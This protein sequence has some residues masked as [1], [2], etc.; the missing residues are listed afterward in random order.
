MKSS[1]IIR[2]HWIEL[3]SHHHQSMKGNYTECL[4]NAS[5]SYMLQK[6]ISV[7]R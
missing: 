7:R 3:V 4:L 2:Q 1:L 6:L 5:P